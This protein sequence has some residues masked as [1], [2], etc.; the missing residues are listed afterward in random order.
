MLQVGRP[1]LSPTFSSSHHQ[2]S[3]AHVGYACFRVAKNKA[4]NAEEFILALSCSKW[5]Y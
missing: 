4:R 5:N 3:P 1:L 2:L